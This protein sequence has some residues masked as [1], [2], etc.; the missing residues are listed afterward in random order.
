[1]TF[2]MADCEQV[3]I[4]KRRLMSALLVPLLCSCLLTVTGC[5]TGQSDSTS[6]PIFQQLSAQEAIAL[7][8][9][10]ANDPMFVILD[11]RTP[12]E[13]ATEHILNAVNID[14]NAPHFDA[15]LDSLDKS[16]AYL[17]YCG[18]GMRSGLAV[19]MMLDRDF[20]EVYELSGGLSSLK[21]ASGGTQLLVPCGCN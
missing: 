9:A 13:F 5:G 11:V 10:R 19:G 20:V 18:S 4:P 15:Q 6:Q 2:V 14:F 16:K 3:T 21:Q 8:A 7:I 1:M 17:V 12:G